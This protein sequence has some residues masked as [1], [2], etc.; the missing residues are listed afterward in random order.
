[1]VLMAC[2]C[3][4]VG[5]HTLVPRRKYLSMCYFLMHPVSLGSVH[6]RSGTDPIVL[7]EFE[8]GFLKA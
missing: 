2:R 4:L 5:D 1:M 3:R 8:T 7:P 6:I